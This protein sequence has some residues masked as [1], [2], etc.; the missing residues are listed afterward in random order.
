VLPRPGALS[1][2][3]LQGQ[4]RRPAAPLEDPGAERGE[5]T[6]QRGQ[7]QHDRLHQ[8]VAVE[9]GI[10]DEVRGVPGLRH[11]L[12]RLVDQRR[13]IHRGMHDPHAQRLPEVAGAQPRAHLR[14][15]SVQ[16]LRRGGQPGP[17]PRHPHGGGRVAAFTAAQRLDDLERLQQPP[18]RHHVLDPG[19]L[20][21]GEREPVLDLAS[22]NIS[23]NP[24]GIA[25]SRE[26]NTNFC[27]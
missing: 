15:E 18:Q 23:I 8:V 1:T 3:R 20:P 4:A 16:R 26:I 13:R 12:Q 14:V 22:Q 21:A 5:V 27:G 25:N 11:H 9:I 19:A 10:E 7:P 2:P 6:R 17:L 24:S